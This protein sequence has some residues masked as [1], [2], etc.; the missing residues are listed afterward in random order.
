MTSA[1][2]DRLPWSAGRWSGLLLVLCLFT[3][4]SFGASLFVTVDTWSFY[5]ALDGDR[6]WERIMRLHVKY[7]LNALT[8]L[9]ISNLV[10][11]LAALLLCRALK[12]QQQSRNEV[13]FVP[14]PVPRTP[15]S[16]DIEPQ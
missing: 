10:W 5:Y 7:T 12:K 1:T 4:V 2:K 14:P 9:L 13:T 8:P 16:F 15:E 6:S 3:L 11:I